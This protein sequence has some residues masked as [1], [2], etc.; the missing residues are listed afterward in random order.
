MTQSG[1]LEMPALERIAKLPASPKAMAG[2]PTA[3]ALPE[4]AYK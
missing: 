1:T 2:G 3:T 4:I